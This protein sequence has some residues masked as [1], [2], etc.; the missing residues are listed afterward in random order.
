MNIAVTGA[1]GFIGTWLLPAAVA[2]GHRV[3]A[4]GR[5]G[6]V[7]SLTA[8]DASV[9]YARTDYSVESLCRILP[10]HD[11]VVHLGAGKFTGEWGLESYLQA[12]AVS[13]AVL[14]ACGQSS[15]ANVVLAS[16]RT[17]YSEHNPLPW[18]EDARVVPL[19]LYGAAKA[20]MEILGEYHS[21]W[22]GLR[23]KSLRLAQVL[24]RGEREGY[25]LATFL[26]RAAAG[27]TLQVHGAGTGRRDFLYVRDAAAAI[28]A[29]LE[30]PEVSGVFNV[31]TGRPVSARQLAEL[32]NA[33]FDNAGNIELRPELPEDRS[34]HVLDVT[35]A[36]ETLGWSARWTLEEALDD[37]RTTL[38]PDA[39]REPPG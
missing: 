10:G 8:G 29:A 7:R 11:A 22:R 35:K 17:V 38:R 16:S 14:E 39:P 21:A 4:L 13:G 12:L 36:R 5:A 32:I 3:T 1:S 31:G 37:L 25:L 34:T 19:N 33:A 28:L 20:A 23:C 24:G 18:S 2:A 9:P 30:K 27:Q 6:D 15:I 26:R